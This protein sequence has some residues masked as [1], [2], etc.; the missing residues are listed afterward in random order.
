MI[1]EDW[2]EQKCFDCIEEGKTAR[3]AFEEMFFYTPTE[4][5]EYVDVMIEVCEENEEVRLD[6]EDIPDMDE[7]NEELWNMTKDTFIELYEAARKARTPEERCKKCKELVIW[8]TEE[9]W[10]VDRSVEH[11]WRKLVAKRRRK[12]GKEDVC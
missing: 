11:V 6:E 1:C 7:L 4:Y 5:A 3:Q 8:A 2:L 12:N 9:E 10:G